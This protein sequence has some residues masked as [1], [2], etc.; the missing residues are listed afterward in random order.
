VRASGTVRAA[1]ATECRTILY[2]YAA[3]E[4]APHGQVTLAVL[5][6][7]HELK[8]ETKTNPAEIAKA[9]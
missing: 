7:G 1:R 4:P 8:T 5:H 2:S 6:C 3:V 9:D